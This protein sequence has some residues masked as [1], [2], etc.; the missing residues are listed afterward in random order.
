[1]NVYR[2]LHVPSA[3]DSLR[4]MFRQRSAVSERLTRAT[5]AGAAVLELPRFRLAVVRRLFPYRATVSWNTLPRD[6][7]GSASLSKVGNLFDK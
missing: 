6:V 2:A 4:A 1:M 5:A 3:P 7:T